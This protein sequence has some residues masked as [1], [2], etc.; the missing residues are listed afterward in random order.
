M[1]VADLLAD[2]AKASPTRDA[3]VAPDGRGGWTR[4]TYGDLDAAV[5]A[6][7]HAFLEDGVRR[8]ELT[9]VMVPPGIPLITLFYACLL[10][11]SDAA[12]E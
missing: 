2:S 12:D 8:G 3:I 9:L 7:G 6:H 10:Y 5:D 4:I 1:N 11:T